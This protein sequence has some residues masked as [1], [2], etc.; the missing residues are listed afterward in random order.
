M[1]GYRAARSYAKI[2]ALVWYSV[3]LLSNIGC[4]VAIRGDMNLLYEVQLGALGYRTT[5]INLHF[6]P[7]KLSSQI[8]TKHKTKVRLAEH[9]KNGN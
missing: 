9:T 5:G 2:Y 6:L 7:E 1:Q 3:V 8:P 4:K